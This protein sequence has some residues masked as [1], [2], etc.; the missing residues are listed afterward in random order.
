MCFGVNAS[1]C[2]AISALSWS[3]SLLIKNIQNKGERYPEA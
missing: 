3:I 1:I 2:G